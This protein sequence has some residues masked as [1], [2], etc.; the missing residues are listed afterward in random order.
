MERDVAPQASHLLDDRVR[1]AADVGCGEALR[2][3][4]GGTA[5]QR[6]YGFRAITPTRFSWDTDTGVP[7]LLARADGE[8]ITGSYLATR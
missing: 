5:D 2:S 3:L 1:A 4:I 8:T 7:C 6:T